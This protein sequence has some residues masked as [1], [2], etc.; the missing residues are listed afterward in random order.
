MPPKKFITKEVSS[1]HVLPNEENLALEIKD[2]K[3]SVFF[4]DGT[5]AVYKY[6]QIAQVIAGQTADIENLQISVENCKKIKSAIEDANP[7][8][9]K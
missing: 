5:N 4:K 8:L 3:Y 7:E 1:T 6:S 9:L 2:Q